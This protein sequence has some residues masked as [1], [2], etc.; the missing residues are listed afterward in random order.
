MV[1]CTLDIIQV[2]IKPLWIQTVDCSALLPI[3]ANSVVATEHGATIQIEA[4][5]HWLI[6]CDREIVLCDLLFSKQ[7]RQLVETARITTCH[8]KPFRYGLSDSSSDT[9]LAIQ[10]RTKSHIGVTFTI[11]VNGQFLQQTHVLQEIASHAIPVS[12][13]W[14]DVVLYALFQRLVSCLAIRRIYQCRDSFCFYLNLS[15]EIQWNHIHQICLWSHRGK[16]CQ[17]LSS[18]RYHGQWH[19]RLIDW[20][21]CQQAVIYHFADL[22]TSWNWANKWNSISRIA[23]RQDRTH[24]QYYWSSMVS[25]RELYM[26]FVFLERSNIQFIPLGHQCLLLD[27]RVPVKRI[28]IFASRSHD[29]RTWW[30][31]WARWSRRFFDLQLYMLHYESQCLQGS[32]TEIHHI[33]L[34]VLNILVRNIDLQF[35]ASCYEQVLLLHVV[36]GY[37]SSE[38][39]LLLEIHILAIWI[40][41]TAYCLVALRRFQHIQIDLQNGLTIERVLLANLQYRSSTWVEELYRR[42]Q[43]LF[44]G[45]QGDRL[46]SGQLQI[47]IVTC[48]LIQE[49][50]AESLS[51]LITRQDSPVIVQQN[52]TSRT[53]CIQVEC[54][55]S[56]VSAIVLNHEVEFLVAVLHCIQVQIEPCFA[57]VHRF[58]T[59]VEVNGFGTSIIYDLWSLI[60]IRCNSDLLGRL[61]LQIDI[62]QS[63]LHQLK[64]R[65]IANVSKRL[66]QCFANCRI[67]DTGKVIRRRHCPNHVFLPLDVILHR[68]I[69]S[70]VLQQ[71]DVTDKQRERIRELQHGTTRKFHMRQLFAGVCQIKG[72]G[73]IL[74]RFIQLG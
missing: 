57:C 16:I 11:V 28:A 70:C 29:S 48:H 45:F 4:K 68:S 73:R 40:H 42:R 60:H 30:T 25:E 64:Q 32:Q 66:L 34:H 14:L 37:R 47:H 21:N 31:R 62:A 52:S 58:A 67:T 2:K 1:T 71:I 23:I 54:H 51:H 12:L 19:I 35:S 49:E 33:A 18:S 39:N 61:H 55:I 7:T 27:G 63:E 41:D 43:H 26:L 59:P 74:R 15:T 56:I 10:S 44:L 46:I 22:H 13:A 50:A 38:R 36:R 69:I 9:I 53:V 72:Y 17:T 8:V 65:H 20:R 3:E 24:H 5:E 6:R